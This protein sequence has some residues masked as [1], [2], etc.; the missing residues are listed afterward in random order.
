MTVT[1]LRRRAKQRLER[2]S[3]QRRAVA[4]DFLAYLE[5]RDVDE[6]TAELLQIPGFITAFEQAQRESAAGD[7]TAVEDL[8]RRS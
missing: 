6:A 8:R 3:P 5:E 2:L 1:E 7:V 4:D